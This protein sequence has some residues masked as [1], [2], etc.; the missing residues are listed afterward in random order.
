[1]SWI[2]IQTKDI[3]ELQQVSTVTS[4]IISIKEDEISS[5]SLI[6]NPLTDKEGK[7]SGNGYAILLLLML[8][9]N[10]QPQSFPVNFI[11]KDK[12]IDKF[13]VPAKATDTLEIT[14]DMLQ[15]DITDAE[16]RS[17]INGVMS[18]IVE[19]EQEVYKSLPQVLNTS[20]INNL[21]YNRLANYK[22]KAG[23]G[24]QGTLF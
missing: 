1:M 6:A 21:L 14:E 18:D 12:S 17:V 16:I 7:P 2:N 23:K 9:G 4:Q 22:A 20:E 10:Q 3:K 15:L 11:L 5:Y 13:F 24:M 19:R 8:K